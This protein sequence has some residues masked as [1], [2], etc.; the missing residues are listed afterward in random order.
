MK[1]RIRSR[2]ARAQRQ[3]F[4]S[5]PNAQH[6]NP[7]PHPKSYRFFLSASRLTANGLASAATNASK[8]NS[9]VRYSATNPHRPPRRPRPALAAPASA[10][11]TP[12]APRVFRGALRIPRTDGSPALPS[13]YPRPDANT[14]PAEEA[15]RRCAGGGAR[16]G[17]PAAPTRRRRGAVSATA[18]DL[19]TRNVG[20][21]PSQGPSSASV[22]A[23]V[24]F[25]RALTLGHAV[26]ADAMSALRS[27]STLA[28]ATRPGGAVR[29]GELLEDGGY[30]LA[31]P[32]PGVAVRSGRRAAARG[33]RDVPRGVEVDDDGLVGAEHALQ[34]ARRRDLVDFLD[35][36]VMMAVVEVAEMWNEDAEL[37]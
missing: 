15:R 4:P 13:R 26:E 17:R 8:L 19:N 14:A 27:V 35:M 9:V 23:L 1:S 5:C 16:D 6:P 28:K 3:C 22:A 2:K 34:L 31:G 24:G 18:P 11:S 32:A 30:G 21:L 25:R 12:P 37:A 10:A 36:A 33:G 7:N 20:I 29:G